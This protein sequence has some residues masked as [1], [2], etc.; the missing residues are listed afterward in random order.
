MKRLLLA[1]TA[2]AAAALAATPASASV[3]FSGFT[4]GCFTVV[5]VPCAPAPGAGVGGL[6]YT[7]GGF[8]QGT[9]DIDNSLGIGGN[10]D[11]FGFFTLSSTTFDYNSSLFNLLI[12]FTLP[13]G[14][15]PNPTTLTANLVGA[16]TSGVNGGI[17]VN[18]ANNLGNPLTFNSSAGTFFLTV[19][20]TSVSSNSTNAYIS[21]RIV[22]AAVPEPAT[23]ALMLLGFG[24]IGMAMRR[25]RQPTLAQVA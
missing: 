18:F 14:T 10:T 21:G 16:V 1:A 17:T 15:S 25:R 12:T 9:N 20:D 3:Q 19:D 7:S 6:T 23:W 8:N 13:A 22:M 24:G 2:G 5:A 4:A 11:N